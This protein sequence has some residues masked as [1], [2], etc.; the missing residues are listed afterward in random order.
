MGFQLL[1]FNIQPRKLLKKSLHLLL[2]QHVGGNQNPPQKMTQWSTTTVDGSDI[3]NNN[4]GC[5]K[6]CK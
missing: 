4:L 5:K 3:Q 1:G 6:N 2:N